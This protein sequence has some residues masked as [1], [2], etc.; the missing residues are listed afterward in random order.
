MDQEIKD[1]EIYLRNLPVAGG[2]EVSEGYFEELENSLI[3]EEENIEI[4]VKEISRLGFEM[5]A[6]YF[7]N[8][9]NKVLAKLE[10]RQEARVIS[11]APQSWY[12]WASSA[13]AVILITLNFVFFEPKEKQTELTSQQISTEDIADHLLES[14]L[15]E[16]LLCDAG[17]C[18]EL[19]KLYGSTDKATNELL[20][21]TDEEILINEL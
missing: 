18:N 13:A 10:K 9:E 5:P 8:L 12:I 1:S 6:N 20:L 3:S 16:D 19:E 7:E 14:D 15:N 21:D 17:W 2:F 4:A 11:I